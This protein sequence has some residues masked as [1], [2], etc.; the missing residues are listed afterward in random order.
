M[1][2]HR[3]SPTRLLAVHWYGFRQIIEVTND[4]L[5]SGAFGTG[6][7]ALLD[8]IQY[9]MLG[10]PWRPNRAAAGNARG[11]VLG[12]LLP[13]RHQHH[14]RRRAPLHMPRGRHHHRTRVHLAGRAKQGRAPPQDARRGS[15]GCASTNTSKAT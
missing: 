10:E 14:A 3:I 8:L 5:I 2:D 12:K 7:P 6:K 11:P 9:V 4:T 15:L 1:N 13:L